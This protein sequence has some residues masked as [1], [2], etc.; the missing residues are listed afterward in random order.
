MSDPRAAIAS[1]LGAHA[2]APAASSLRRVVASVSER[3]PPCWGELGEQFTRHLTTDEARIKLFER[4]RSVGDLGALVLFL[5]LNRA[6]PGVLAHVWSV[7]PDLPATAQCALVSLD[8]DEPH[9]S[10]LAACLHPA[11]RIL[12]V[13]PRA[14]AR[15]RGFYAALATSLRAQR[16]RPSPIPE[17][18]SVAPTP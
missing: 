3:L 8:D 1:A 5:D 4:L 16:T 7:A 6:R 15:D 14:R 17:P 10:V 11:A 18:A 12:L 13:N 9:H 2:S